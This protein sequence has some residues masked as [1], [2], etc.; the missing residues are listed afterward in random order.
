MGLRSRTSSRALGT[1]VVFVH[2]S[3]ADMRTWGYQMAPVGAS[4]RAIAYS[5]RFHHPNEAAEGGPPYTAAPRRRPRGLH[6]AVARRRGAPRRVVVR[7]LSPYSTARDCPDLVRSMV[8]T[9]PAL[10]ALLPSSA[11]ER[12]TARRAPRSPASDWSPA[13]HGGQRSAPSSTPSSGQA[14]RFDVGVHARDDQPTTCRRS[15]ARRP[16]LIPILR[17]VCRCRPRPR[18]GAAPDRRIQPGLL[19]RDR[20]APGR[21]PPARRG[22][23][24]PRRSACRPRPAARPFQRAGGGVPCETRGEVAARE[25]VPT[26]CQLPT[27]NYQLPT[28]NYQLPT[29]NYQLPTAKS[30]TV[31]AAGWRCRTVPCQRSPSRP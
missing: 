12:V 4:Y 9:E 26:H 22:G 30:P 15:V 16:H 7:G 27:T 13:T 29:T 20:A 17:S 6:R 10:F 23:D 24:G 21:L 31:G 1:V 8:L 3:G 18:A 5:R 14:R 11:P 2:G 28:T 25:W 19:P